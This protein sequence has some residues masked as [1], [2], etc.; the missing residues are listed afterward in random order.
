MTTTTKNAI[1]IK[2][3]YAHSNV[4][5]PLFSFNLLSTD[6]HYL[7]Y[8]STRNQS[9]VRNKEKK[10]SVANKNICTVHIDLVIVFYDGLTLCLYM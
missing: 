6:K 9:Y 3:T 10:I 4:I 5:I 7:N 1:I 8:F 2:N